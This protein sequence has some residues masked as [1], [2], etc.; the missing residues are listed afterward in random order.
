MDTAEFKKHILPFREKLY[1]IAL[2]LLSDKQEAED[3]IQDTYLKL[4]NMRKQL[5]EYRSIEALAV[6]M[7]KNQCFDKLKSYKHRKQDNT[8]VGT[9]PLVGVAPLPDRSTEIKDK[10]K[11]FNQI[12]NSLPEQQKLM[13]HLREVEQ[14]EYDEIVEM[15]GVARGTLRV[16][17][18]RARK[19]IR[20][21]YMKKYSHED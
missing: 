18:S 3:T 19:K 13:V 1:R 8:D 14:Y 10:M 21:E 17:L 5:S 16:M 9:I 15:T 6:T 11:V 2:S 4:W 7:T 12:L 20:A